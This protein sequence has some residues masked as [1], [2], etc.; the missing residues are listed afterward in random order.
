MRMNDVHTNDTPESFWHSRLW[1]QAPEMWRRGYVNESWWDRALDYGK[2]EVREHHLALI[3]ELLDRYDMDG[4]ELDWIRSV[5]HFAPG[6]E[7]QGLPILTEFV[8]EARV[9]VE[10][11]SKRRNHPIKLG[12]RLPEDPIVS[13]RFGMDGPVWIRE[14]LVDQVVLSQFLSA[15]SFDSP[16]EIWKD[17]IGDKEITL[18][19]NFSTST[20]PFNRDQLGRSG[21]RSLNNTIEL[22]R[23]AALGAYHKGF[24]SVYLFNYC[25]YATSEPEYLQTILSELGSPEAMLDKPRRHLTSYQELAA[26][27]MPESSVLPARFDEIR[28]VSKY[29]SIVTLSLYVGPAPKAR[30][31][32][33]VVGFLSGV[34]LP[35]GPDDLHIR[36]NGTSCPYDAD[37]AMPAEC[38]D[39]VEPRFGFVVADGVLHDGRNT[40]EVESTSQR[41]TVV[42]AEAYIQ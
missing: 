35:T 2:A 5:Q 4:L 23:G 21:L 42:W 31:T 7:E 20:C 38:P 6:F 40:L 18:A 3:R 39:W 15:I 34:D 29:G 22:L 19:L 16:I 33:V 17:L 32:T 41:G 8:R 12:V 9:L 25:Y 27:G 13:K 30:P 28:G 14:G 24:D 11:A 10:Q 1:Q 36:V 37:A 26:P